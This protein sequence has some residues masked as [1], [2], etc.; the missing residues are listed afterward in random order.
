MKIG[1][2]TSGGDCQALNAA[3]RGVVKGLANNVD[4][5]D[6][7]GFYNGYKGAAHVICGHTPTPFIKSDWYY[8]IRLRNKITLMDTGSF[9]PKGKISCIDILSDQ[10]WQ[11]G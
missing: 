5:L 6:V 8:P 2:L 11:S 7:Y 3:M 1:M 4:D 10:I 9:M